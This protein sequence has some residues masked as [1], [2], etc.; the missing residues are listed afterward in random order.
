[1]RTLLNA[2]LLLCTTA[3]MLFGP[4]TAVAAGSDRTGT[5][6]R[7]DFSGSGR[8]PLRP[9]PTVEKPF[10][11]I[12]PHWKEGQPMLAVAYVSG[13][14]PVVGITLDVPGQNLSA[15]TI[16][17]G[18][19]PDG[20]DFPPTPVAP[21]VAGTHA[22]LVYPPHSASRPFQP[23]A[24]CS[25]EPFTISWETSVDGGAHWKAQAESRCTLYITRSSPVREAPETGY[26][27]FESLFAMSCRNAS[28]A[29][30]DSAII[31]GI[32]TQFA[33]RSVRLLSGDTLAFYR[34]KNAA[35]ETTTGGLIFTKT[36]I[37]FAWAHLLIDL[38]RVQGIQPHN[39][40]VVLSTPE[41]T[42]YGPVVGMLIQNC[43]FMTPSGTV[44][45]PDY[46]YV[47]AFDPHTNLDLVGPDVFSRP[48]IAA[49]GE[50]D[51]VSLFRNHALVCLDGVYY[52]PSY[53]RTYA[54]ID[55]FYNVIAGWV[56][57]GRGNEMA[58]K[59]D[60]NGDGTID[61]TDVTVGRVSNNPHRLALN[62]TRQDY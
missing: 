60:L 29:A 13:T 30:S 11:E 62:V 59:F 51:P 45:C 4:A 42:Q 49:Q 61:N 10:T 31:K 36:G 16:V 40:Y 15:T 12:E 57:L 39:S 46:P 3:V 47:A 43:Q 27:F 44:E 58:M 6:T 33:D 55:E 7:M 20:I 21:S 9:D 32:W 25:Y 54:S 8:I 50:P 35:P 34:H 1:M 17:R 24:I 22:T 41:S 48:G 37:C 52:D 38:L 53:G 56:V 18:V 26:A 23:G 14:I 19:G 5:V 2:V 28:G